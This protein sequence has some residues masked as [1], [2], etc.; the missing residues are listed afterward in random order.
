E[1]RP[2]PEKLLM[3]R[4]IGGSLQLDAPI[5]GEESDGY[6][7]RESGRYFQSRGSRVTLTQSS[8][9]TTTRATAPNRTTS[10]HCG[11]APSIGKQEEG[12]GANETCRCTNCS[13]DAANKYKS[14]TALERLR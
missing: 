13:N 12:D 8:A 2:W 10:F 4:L 1:R 7:P 3:N 5:A 11:C 9:S 6:E 14:L